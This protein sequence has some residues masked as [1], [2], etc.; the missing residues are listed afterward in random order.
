VRNWL[1]TG[2]HRHGTIFWRVLLPETEPDRPRC[3][4]VT[5]RDL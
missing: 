2:G 3:K 1:D 4:V 5:V